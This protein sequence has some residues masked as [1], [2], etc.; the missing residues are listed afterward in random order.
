MVWIGF[1]FAATLLQWALD[2]AHLLSET[3]AIR[4]RVVAGV[5]VILVGLYQL[6]PLKQ[7]F[8]RR[9][10]ARLTGA[11]LVAWGSV[12]LALAVF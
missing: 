1:S 8:L 12:S 6:T 10:T 7:T 9:C 3:M 2:S 4:S 5:L 11:V